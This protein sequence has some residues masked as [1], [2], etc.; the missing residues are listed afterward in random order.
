[1]TAS[2]IPPT[3]M[4]ERAEVFSRGLREVTSPVLENAGFVFDKSRSYRRIDTARGRLHLINFQLG[5]RRLEGKF[6]V[7]IGWLPSADVI[8]FK[9]EKTRIYQ[10][11][12]WQRLGTLLPPAYP[13]LS[14]IP[15]IGF[16][17]MP[18]DRWWRFSEDPE[19]CFAQLR[20]VTGLIESH[21]L[22]WLSTLDSSMAQNPNLEPTA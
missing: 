22:K 14:R 20:L 9:L 4:T 15:V 11:R 3:G 8:D 21:G 19:F 5:Q 10:C 16:L 2:T 18:H 12:D 13:G 7:N 1:M 6:T 17:F